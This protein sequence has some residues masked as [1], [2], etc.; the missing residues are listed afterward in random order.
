MLCG[1]FAARGLA[2]AVRKSPQP[3]LT[4]SS[5]RGAR[6]R[7]LCQAA[8]LLSRPRRRALRLVARL[9]CSPGGKP[10]DKLA[11]VASLARAEWGA[12]TRKLSGCKPKVACKLAAGRPD[13][14]ICAHNGKL[15]SFVV[16]VEAQNSRR[17]RSGEKFYP[18]ARA[19]TVRARESCSVL[20]ALPTSSESSSCGQ[21]AR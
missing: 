6:A 16:V 1:E 7:P 4:A 15:A 18:P 17:R 13:D 9:A 8:A 19:L 10:A 3:G 12:R 14:K 21:V 11:A 5:T 2:R 20:L